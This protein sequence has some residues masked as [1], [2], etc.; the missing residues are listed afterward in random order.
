MHVVART[1]NI[2]HTHTPMCG[3]TAECGGR[4]GRLVAP[5]FWGAE[6]HGRVAP[7]AFAVTILVVSLAIVVAHAE[8][9]TTTGCADIVTMLPFGVV[10]IARRQL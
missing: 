2:T 7:V 4:N 8:V 5:P 3:A 9:T 6:D 1:S 10:T